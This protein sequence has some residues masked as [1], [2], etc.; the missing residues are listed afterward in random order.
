MNKDEIRQAA[1]ND[2]KVFARLVNP[3][4][5]YG[6][7]HD[8]LFDFWQYGGHDNT[9]TLLPRDHR[10]SHCLA[11]L[12][13]W[14]VVKNPWETQLYVSATAD[15]A[16]KQLYAIKNMLDNRIMTQQ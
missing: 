5:V 15:L 10:K 9:L 3:S 12:T 2:L 4:S 13:A 1:E 8:E 7:I 14:Q 6:A 11:V 16:E